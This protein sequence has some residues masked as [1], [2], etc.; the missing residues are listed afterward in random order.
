MR[1]RTL[2]IS[3]LVAAA[4]TIVALGGCATSVPPP[5]YYGEPI[6]A[7]SVA[8]GVVD[9]VR[10]IQFQGADTGLGT[11]GGAALGGWAGSGIG[12]GSGNAAAIVGGVL[13]GS[14]IG[15]AVERE[16]NRRPGVE[17]IVRLDAGRTIAV[18]QDDTGEAFRPGDRIRVLSD[19][20]RTRV[21]R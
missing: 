14:L 8:L 6:R 3:A 9:D 4:A 12:S 16:A 19:G 21:T 15:N 10:S 5:Y 7:P 20:Y 13:L 2:R 11:L 18:V 17:V 1:Q